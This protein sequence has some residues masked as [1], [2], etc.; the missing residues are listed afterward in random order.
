MGSCSSSNK[1]SEEKKDESYEKDIDEFL[2]LIKNHRSVKP[3]QIKNIYTKIMNKPKSI[4]YNRDQSLAYLTIPEV[5]TFLVDFIY[6]LYT[7]YKPGIS[8]KNIRLLLFP[9]PPKYSIAVLRFHITV[10]DIFD[11][12]PLLGI[13]SLYVHSR[14]S[15][16]ISGIHELYC[17]KEDTRC[18]AV[19][20]LKKWRPKLDISKTQIAQKKILN[21]DD[22]STLIRLLFSPKTP[23]PPPLTL[24]FSTESGE[25]IITPDGKIKNR[26]HGSQQSHI[27]G[28]V[29]RAYRQKPT[30]KQHNKKKIVE[31]HT[32]RKQITN[33]T[34]RPTV[35][36]HIPTQREKRRETLVRN[37]S[38]SKSSPIIRNTDTWDCLPPTFSSVN[39]KTGPPQ[40][41][42]NK[43][44][45]SPPRQYDTNDEQPTTAPPPYDEN[46]EISTHL[47][48]KY[49]QYDDN[50]E[51]PPSYEDLRAPGGPY[52]PTTFGL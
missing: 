13:R 43:D 23:S 17:R 38:I 50:K 18:S 16:I 4:Y 10:D 33:P 2:R 48:N 30:H 20:V 49:S 37:W 29:A 21:T 46:I 22:T 28:D 9:I 39:L 34:T 25:L 40:Y 52:D 7:G 47:P 26:Y 42:D 1:T 31:N 3:Q 35:K 11:L 45:P 8:A 19:N 27:I 6:K 12:P 15:R 24:Y 5:D 14:S 41:D 36:I 44:K 51:Q 32:E